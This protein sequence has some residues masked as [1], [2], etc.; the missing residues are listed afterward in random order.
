MDGDTVLLNTVG[1]GQEFVLDCQD[2]PEAV[3]WLSQ[4][5]CLYDIGSAKPLGWKLVPERYELR[6]PRLTPK[7]RTSNSPT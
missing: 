7:H 3:Q 6:M 4:L 1:R 5:L 2:Y